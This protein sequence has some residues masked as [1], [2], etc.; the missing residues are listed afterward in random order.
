MS[1]YSETSAYT[2]EHFEADVMNAGTA[3]NV[4]WIVDKYHVGTRQV[5]VGR[6]LLKRCTR[7]KGEAPRKLVADIVR[8]ARFRHRHNRGLYRHVM[9]A[10]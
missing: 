9:G 7:G 6:D 5:E 8:Y 10:L 4:R 3:S 1:A 2:G